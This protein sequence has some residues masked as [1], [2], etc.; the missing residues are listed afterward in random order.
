MHQ[1]ECKECRAWR[2]DEK[3]PFVHE[4]TCSYKIDDS[5]LDSYIDRVIGELIDEDTENRS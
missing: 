1:V 5:E 4:K 3:F 2:L